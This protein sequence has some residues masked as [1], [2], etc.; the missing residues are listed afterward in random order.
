MHTGNE[1]T[2]KKNR[3]GA[4]VRLFVFVGL[5]VFFVWL[6][7]RSMGRKD[8][9]EMREAIASINSAAGWTMIAVAAFFCIMADVVRAIR[10]RMLLL[11]LHYKVRHSMAFYSVMVCYLANLAI[12]RLGEVLRCTFLQRYEKVP[13]QK[14]LGTVLTERAVDILCW[15]LLLCTAVAMNTGMLGNLVIDKETNLSVGMWMEQKGL[16]LLGNYLIYIII[17]VVVLTGVIGRLTRKWWMGIPFFV[18]IR[19]FLVG[20]WQGLI[21]IKNLPHPWRFVFWTVMLW[22]CYFMGTFMFFFA[23][24]YLRSVGPGAAFAVLVFSTIAFMISQGGLGSYPLIA[25]GILMLYGIDYTQGLAAGWVGWILQTALILVFG[26]LSLV[27]TSFSKIRDSH[28]VLTA[29]PANPGKPLDSH[30]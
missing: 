17:G 15:L 25:A 8:F 28:G 2:A 14:S 27:L 30:G 13:F 18:K 22:V 3:I 11:P 7:V 26:L 24:P 16:S 29:L 6:S 20:I 21:S 4:L 23:M 12:P 10:A 9:M 5:G 1:H 19:N